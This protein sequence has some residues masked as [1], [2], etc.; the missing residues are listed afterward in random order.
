MPETLQDVTQF[1]TTT[2]LTPLVHRVLGMNPAT[3]TGPGTNT[4]LVGAEGREPLLIDSGS[5]VPAWLELLRRHLAQHGLKAPARCLF[6]HAHGDHVGGMA[7]LRGAFPEIRFFKRPWP[8]RD[9]EPADRLDEGDEIHGEGYTLRAVHTPGHAPDHLCFL[10]EEERALFT[11]DVVLGVGTTV[12]PLEGGDLGM[13]LET[14]RRLQ[15][16]DL[17]R[18]YP[19]HGPVIDAPREKVAYYLEHRLERERQILALLAQ[20]VQTVTDLVAH[21]YKNYPPALHTAAGQ[22]VLSHLI[23]LEREGRVRRQGDVLP[24]FLLCDSETPASLPDTHSSAT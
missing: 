18:I 8:G 14:L 24:R 3:F 15:T 12:I 5:G 9:P 11:G 2:R 23:K 22:S 7:Q 19:G 4:Y 6:T 21:I 17:A 1:P 13:Y 16:L 10:L 20:G